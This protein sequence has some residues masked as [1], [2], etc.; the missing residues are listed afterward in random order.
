MVEIETIIQEEVEP[1]TA[2]AVLPDED[3]SALPNKEDLAD[4]DDSSSPENDAPNNSK[5]NQERVE[6]G[7][8]GWEQLMGKDLLLKVRWFHV[9]ERDRYDD[10]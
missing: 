6:I 4:E 8:E 10:Q 9:C 3:P 1:T 7:T 2:G 5:N